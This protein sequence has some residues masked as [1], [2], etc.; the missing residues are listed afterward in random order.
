MAE[1]SSPKAGTEGILEALAFRFVGAGGLLRRMTG[2]AHMDP[3]TGNTPAA[4]DLP[5]A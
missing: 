3:T 1:S 5:S 2:A 4:E